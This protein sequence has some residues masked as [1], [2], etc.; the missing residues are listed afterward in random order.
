[1]KLNIKTIFKTRFIVV[2]VIR[3]FPVICVLNGE[4]PLVLSVATNLDVDFNFQ[5]CNNNENEYQHFFF[6]SSA[7]VDLLFGVQYWFA[8]PIQ[9]LQ[10]ILGNFISFF[11]VA[12]V[13]YHWR[14]M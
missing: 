8:Y 10:A 12:P 13:L 7:F 11:V 5:R 6:I 4:L 3:Y 1:M 2:F 9:L 14:F